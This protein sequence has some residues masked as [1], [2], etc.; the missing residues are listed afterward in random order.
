MVTRL[1]LGIILSFGLLNAGF[2]ADARIKHRLMFFE[3][4]NCPES[5]R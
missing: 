4:G 5:L 2:A 1:A 3:Y